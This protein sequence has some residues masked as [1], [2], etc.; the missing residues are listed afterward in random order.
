M[1]IDQWL[2]S[3]SI[4]NGVV[5]LSNVEGDYVKIIWRSWKIICGIINQNIHIFKIFSLFKKCKSK[6][7]A[8]FCKQ[9]PSAFSVL[10]LNFLYG[11]ELNTERWTLFLIKF[12]FTHSGKILNSFAFKNNFPFKNFLDVEQIGIRPLIY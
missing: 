1:S 9:R 5:T 10:A 12:T 8:K 11:W 3:E 4:C 7:F 2:C 6:I